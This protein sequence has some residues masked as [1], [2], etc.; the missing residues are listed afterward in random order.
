MD[1]PSTYTNE[2][3]TQ[4]MAEINK[5]IEDFDFDTA[6]AMLEVKLRAEPNNI[7][8]IDTMAEVLM[9]LDE[10]DAAEKLFKKSISL[11]PNKNAEKY[12]TLGQLSDCRSALKLYEKGVHIFMN[13]LNVELD[14]DKRVKIRDS[15]AS[16]YAAI[17]ELHM[18]TDLW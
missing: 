4:E 15:L 5:L 14:E 3:N 12:M 7:E 1:K 17:A 13:D 9:N 18:N 11:E 8:Y 16:A 6:K 10:S 2:N